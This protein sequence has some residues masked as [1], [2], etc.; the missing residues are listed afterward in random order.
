MDQKRWWLKKE[1]EKENFGIWKSDNLV[2][3]KYFFY[4][5]KEQDREVG[6]DFGEA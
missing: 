6:N 2:N 1:V 4:A 3:K 5:A